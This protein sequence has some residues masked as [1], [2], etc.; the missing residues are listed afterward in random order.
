MNYDPSTLE[1]ELRKLQAAPLD[2]ALLARLEASAD[3]TWTEL[4]HE[5]R[6]FEN[7][8]R[9]KAPARLSADFLSQLES[10][11]TGVHFPMDEKVILFPNG[12]TPRTKRHN[13][14]M[15]AAAAAVALIGAASALLVPTTEKPVANTRSSN[16][17]AAPAL[18]AAT[19][20]SFVP[21]SF[22]RGLSEVHDEGVV[23]KSNK[24]PHRLVRVVYTDLVTLKDASGRT[25]EVEQPRVKYMLVPDKTD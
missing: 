15:W 14:P 23:W 12:S 21:A 3:D 20:N 16:G 2:E 6:H 13:R 7:L 11:T 1:A 19:T 22:N 4:T 9:E 8:L 5:E 10:V 24:Q 17:S 18:A 25:V